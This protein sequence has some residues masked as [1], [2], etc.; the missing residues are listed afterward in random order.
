MNRLL[1]AGIVLVV[2]AIAST[3]FLIPSE[4]VVSK[5]AVL[6]CNRDGAYRILR[7]TGGWI[8]WWPREGTGGQD[9]DGDKL[10]F[11]GVGYRMS[12]LLLRGADIVC[13]DKGNEI[14][15]ELTIYP[16]GGIDSC[17]LQWQF[18]QKASWNPFKRIGQY[19]DA[20]RLKEGMGVILDS[21]GGYLGNRVSVYGVA[22]TEASTKDSCLVETSSMRK[23]YPGT[24]VLYDA[25][26][27]LE[28]FAGA[29]G[30]TRTGYPM[31]NV[32]PLKDGQYHVRVAIPV[33]RKLADSGDI[34]YRKLIRGNYLESDVR[35]GPGAVNA[36]LAGM[37]N[38][39]RDYR[40]TVMAIPFFS[41]LTDR[42]KE[43]DS[44]RW[45]TRIYYPIY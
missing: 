39:I 35:G 16:L 38:Y 5:I 44:T 1:T 43:P 22:I 9:R 6:N 2:L 14:P 15:S 31:V 19:R 25:V 28:S 20:K 42:T 18:T 30:G 4:L 45:L 40:R 8:K 10:S 37:N 24:P 41:L 17:Y 26:H 12:Q 13:Y 7:D 36:A 33:D 29:R 21:L 3:Y 27:R 23:D 11:R 32:D 34:V